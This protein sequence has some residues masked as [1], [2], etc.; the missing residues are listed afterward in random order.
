MPDVQTEDKQSRW[1]KEEFFQKNDFT[2]HDGK[3]SPN[4]HRLVLKN[5]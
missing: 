1:E 2:D 4:Y 5:Q 3:L